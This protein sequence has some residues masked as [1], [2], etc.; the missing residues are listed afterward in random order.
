MNLHGPLGC[1]GDEETRR[2]SKGVGNPAN[3]AG[4]Y[5]KGGI[6]GGLRDADNYAE[7]RSSHQPEGDAFH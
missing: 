3:Y 4:D 1:L 2:V 6:R 7:N 5:Y